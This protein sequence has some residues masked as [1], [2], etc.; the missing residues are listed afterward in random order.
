MSITKDVP[1]AGLENVPNEV[2]A[3]HPQKSTLERAIWLEQQKG[4]CPRPN[5]TS[6]DFIIPPQ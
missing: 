6:Q 5:P 2:L 4:N 1:E 3:N